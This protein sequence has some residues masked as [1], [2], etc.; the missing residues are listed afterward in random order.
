MTFK[1][2]AVA[3]LAL[4]ASTA[5]LLAQTTPAQASQVN[6][7]ANAFDDPGL[8]RA[9]NDNAALYTRTWTGAVA[10]LLPAFDAGGATK[11]FA[12][13]S[14][15]AHGTA[16]VD[17]TTGSFTFTASNNSRGGDSLVYRVTT[18]NESKQA[19]LN[20]E[21][22][23]I[24][25]SFL[26]LPGLSNPLAPTSAVPEST[27]G[28][29]STPVDL[30]S[31]GD[32]DLVLT[33]SSG[34][35][36]YWR[37]DGTA[38]APYF[39]A[40]SATTQLL[41]VAL[42]DTDC[43]PHDG[44]PGD[45]NPNLAATGVEGVEC[46][47]L[48]AVDYEGDGDVDFLQYSP[49]FGELIAAP[50][51]GVQLFRNVGS[52]TT[53]SLVDY[54]ATGKPFGSSAELAS[55]PYS[56]FTIS[57]VTET[58]NPAAVAE[59]DGT[60][61]LT[62]FATLDQAWWP[63]GSPTVDPLY[64]A[65][66]GLANLFFPQVTFA[67]VDGDG[68]QDLFL[69]ANRVVSPNS[70]QYRQNTGTTSA[71]SFP[72]W[73]N[74]LSDPLFCINCDAVFADLDG[75][76]DPDLIVDGSGVNFDTPYYYRNDSRFY[77]TDDAPAASSVFANG[78][79]NTAD[80][81]SVALTYIYS[82]PEGDG[83]SGSTF[84]WQRATDA[85]GAGTINI[86]GATF[87]TYSMVQADV[88]RWLRGCVTPSDGNSAGAQ[89]CSSWMLTV[90]AANFYADSAYSGT[91]DRVPYTW[92]S[93][94]GNGACQ[95]MPGSVGDNAVSSLKLFG[96]ASQRTALVYYD[97]ASCAGA[98]AAL[99]AAAGQTA[100]NPVL[101][102]TGWADRA[103]SYRVLWN[104]SASKSMN[105]TCYTPGT[106]LLQT[107]LASLTLDANGNLVLRKTIPGNNTT[108]IAWQSH[109]DGQSVAK[110][111]LQSDG[112]LVLLTGSGQSV[113]SSGTNVAGSTLSLREDCNFAVVGPSSQSLWATST[114]ECWARTYNLVAR[115]SSKMMDVSQ[116]SQANGA[117][118]WQWIAN[119]QD[120]QRW[121]LRDAGDGWY[122]IVAQHSYKCAGVGGNTPG[123]QA[124]QWDCWG[125]EDQKW[126]LLPDGA[127]YYSIR[128]KN[129]G[130]CLDV[131][132]VST[133]DSAKVVQWGCN[134]NNNQKWRLAL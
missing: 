80:L 13:V 133:A 8:H 76:G 117:P 17:A 94:G 87:S 102:T 74:P 78:E 83:E 35:I 124:S 32:L 44:H 16:S 30:D 40:D 45:T 98:S 54:T 24:K 71:P 116:V 128:S 66:S 9:A 99:I 52:R 97:D 37:N 49:V 126:A 125:G 112:N 46:R 109:T 56:G 89:A 25:Q 86:P 123:T 3:L 107:E 2:A 43:H 21:V 53:P 38:Y 92:N 36:N 61:L 79:V 34:K 15:P 23:M 93:L 106:T 48:A 82:D 1:L 60:S 77:A 67:D 96:R 122:Y 41:Q 113:W 62:F 18:A 6:P 127:G 81:G 75:D 119:G 90:P 114:G 57:D 39:V 58:G 64:N 134:G 84:Q 108:W 63:Y 14:G 50:T 130:L 110:A 12:L 73:T 132:Q 29:Y 111:C 104:G 55:T 115:H 10:G 59:N 85:N 103:S 51:S 68:D 28:T 100:V 88:D 105:G 7:Y 91:S 26:L 69:T 4:G 47:A 101:G 70:M 72:S 5:G 11:T 129:S 20:I 65:V 19:T 95:N 33:N 121:T 31:D 42:D 131:Y 22:G 118:I 27:G 120:N